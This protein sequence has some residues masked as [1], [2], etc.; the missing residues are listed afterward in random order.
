[1]EALARNSMAVWRTGEASSADT[2]PIRRP[3][4]RIAACRPAG[5]G[6]AQLKKTC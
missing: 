6:I 1:V 2:W 3:A 5:N 4:K